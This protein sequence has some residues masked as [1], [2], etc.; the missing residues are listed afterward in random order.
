MSRI[1]PTHHGWSPQDRCLRAIVLQQTRRQTA[2]QVA[3]H[4]V[5]DALHEAGQERGRA[6]NMRYSQ[7]RGEPIA[8]AVKLGTNVI[9]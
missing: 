7:R 4:H 1:P 8:G 9:G 2:R 5:T 6:Q 3:S